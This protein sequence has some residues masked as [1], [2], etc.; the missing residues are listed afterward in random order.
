[1]VRDT[2]NDLDIVHDFPDIEASQRERS[3]LQY[4]LGW[5]RKGKYL[6]NHI[7]VHWTSLLP[8]DW[9]R[10]GKSIGLEAGVNRTQVTGPLADLS[11]IDSEHLPYKTM[12]HGFGARIRL[13]KYTAIGVQ[14]FH[15]MVF[16]DLFGVRSLH[17]LEGKVG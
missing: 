14:Y 12:S 4:Y 1:M 5:K 15:T 11:G 9:G 7:T 3:G 10:N 8:S 16:Q 2:V 6:G 17:R 13:W